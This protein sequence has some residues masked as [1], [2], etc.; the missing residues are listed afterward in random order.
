MTSNHI[1][2]LSSTEIA[3]LWST[4]INDSLSICI[5]KHFLHHSN[6]EDVKPLIKLSIE[7]SENHIEEIKAIFEKEKIPTPKGFSDEDIDLSVGALFFDLFPISYAYGMSRISLMTYGILVSNVAR[8]DIRDFFSKCLTSA[9]DLYNT[10]VNLMLS[11]GIYDRPPMI[12]Y[13]EKIEFV[14]EKDT[15][16]SKWLEKKRPLNVLEISEMFFNIER[17]YFGLVILTGFIQVAKDD[18]IKQFLLKGKELALK[19]INFLNHTF[20]KDDLLG[21]IMVNSEVT[22]STLS[23]FS[24]KLI[25]N[26][27]TSLNTQGI[28]YLGHALSISSRIDLASEYLKLIPE[29]LQYG[30]EGTEIMIKRGWMEEPPHAPDRGELANS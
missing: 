25:M 4:Y 8:K 16:L 14:K 22:T 9:L 7:K 27:V 21:T 3:G 18:E 29:I 26:L 5:S 23:P 6:N 30:K 11:K 24:D 10:T 19:Q 1:V 2:G 17:N 12:P 20:T 13:P 28:S 15:F